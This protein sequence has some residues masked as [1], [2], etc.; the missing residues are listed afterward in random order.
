MI[1][2]DR[3]H[4]HAGAKQKK[5]A[6]SLCGQYVIAGCVPIFNGPVRLAFHWIEPNSRRDID[7]I[8]GGAKFILD[9]LV[10]TGRLKNDSRAHVKSIT[11]HFPE[12]DKANPRI[13]V[14][15]ETI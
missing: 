6:T 2:A 5:E 12:P 10:L 4:Y 15:I 8:S 7:N 3:S 14:E 1:A 9:G 11:H 13:V